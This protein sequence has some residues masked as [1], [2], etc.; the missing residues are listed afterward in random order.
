LKRSKN[1]QQI[2]Y[3]TSHNNSCA[4][5]ERETLQVFL[6]KTRAQSCRG[7]PLGSIRIT[8]VVAVVDRDMLTRVGQNG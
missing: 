4:N 6:K 1:S 3:A 7:L 8:A 2:N 5:R